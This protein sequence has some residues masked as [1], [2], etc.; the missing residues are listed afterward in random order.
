M[1]LIETWSKRARYLSSVASAWFAFASTAGISCSTYLAPPAY[2]DT[3]SRRSEI[4][5]TSASVCLETRSAVRCRVPVS[6]D[7][8][9]GSGVSWTF[10]H[11]I[12]VA[13]CD[14]VIA[15]SIFASW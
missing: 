14:S 4:V 13:L 5:T 10:A 8:M 15:P 7:R 3:T 6:R 1:S 2:S 9:V 11:M 12:L